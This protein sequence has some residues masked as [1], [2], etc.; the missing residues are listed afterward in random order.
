MF[1]ARASLLATEFT[2]FQND[3]SSGGIRKGESGG[4]RTERER[5]RER[6][7]LARVVLERLNVDGDHAQ[8]CTP[9]ECN[10]A[11][12]G[13]LHIAH[14]RSRCPVTVYP[15]AAYTRLGES[16]VGYPLPPGETPRETF[17]PGLCTRATRTT[18]A[19]SS[20]RSSSFCM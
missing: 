4:V 3:A 2:G 8:I 12:G 1:A 14:L 5:K 15:I 20:S 7:F 11:L 10:V 16:I 19:R 9:R 6:I 13:V 18:A 17:S